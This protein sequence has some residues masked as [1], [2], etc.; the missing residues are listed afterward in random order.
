MSAT[1]IPLDDTVPEWGASRYLD[2]QL[3]AE[4]VV[5]DLLEHLFVL[6]PV[7]DDDKHYWVG[8]DEVDKLLRRGG[9]WL[10]A[11]P[12][13]ELITR[14]YLR[15]DRRLTSDAIARLVAADDSAT[16]PDE[17]AE[18]H[19]VEEAEVERPVR[20]NDQRLAAVTEALQAAGAHRVVDLGCGP[21]SLLNVLLKASWIEKVVGVDVSWRSLEIA[22]R[23]LRLDE[24]P[25][26][27]RERVD[28]WQG[29]L[30]YRDK[31]LAWLRR[32]RGSRGHRASRSA[33]S[34]RVRTSAVRRRP[35]GD[36]GRHDAERRVQRPVRRPSRRERCAIGTT[37]S[38]GLGPSSRRGAMRVSAAHGYTVTASGI[39]PIDDVLGSPTQMAV[40]RR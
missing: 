5:K 6:L 11:H 33:A 34:R 23:R 26:R 27:Q 28:L 38:S 24:M 31:R 3:T 4:V 19:D 7:L 30:T 36:G 22:A 17:T 16:D 21:G 13:R 1:E 2:V 37:A 10:V 14:R 29:A 35:A 40:F 15:H 8:D 32:G 39:G 9:D 20:L 12:E 25:P 18:A